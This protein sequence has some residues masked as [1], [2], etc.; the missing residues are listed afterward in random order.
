[1]MRPD[2]AALLNNHLIK[3]YYINISQI[4]SV[5]NIHLAFSGVTRERL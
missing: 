2:R 3:I 5:Q 1:M 4:I